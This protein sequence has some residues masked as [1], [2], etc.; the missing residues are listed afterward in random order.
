MRDLVLLR[1]E[2]VELPVREDVVEDHQALER[3]AQRHPLAEPN[4]SLLDGVV[5]SRVVQVKDA[6]LVV[7][8]AV[9]CRELAARQFVEEVDQLLSAGDAREGAVLPR[10][11]RN[12]NAASLRPGRRPGAP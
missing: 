5:Q 2:P 1:P 10:P 6:G 8:A 7:A 4:V 12:R 3:P 9:R 11:E